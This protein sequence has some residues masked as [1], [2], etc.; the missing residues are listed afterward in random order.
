[1]VAKSKDDQEITVFRGLDGVV[2]AETDISFVDGIQGDLYYK[3]YNIHD[4]ADN[5][6]SY[7]EVVY[8][9]LNGELPTIRQLRDFRRKA[10]SDMRV[11]TQVIKM[12]EIMPPSS[13]PMDV[14]RTAVSA[15]SHFDSDA[16][17]DSPKASRRKGI[18]LIAQIPTLVASLYRIRNNKNIVSPDP[19]MNMAENILY[20]F[21]GSIPEKNH[22]G[23][24]DLLL[25]LHA[26]HGL[27]A[28]TFAARVA[29][30]THADMHAA[31]TSALSTLKGPLHG[32]ANERVMKMLRKINNVNEVEAY[33][34]SMLAQGQRVMGFGHRVYN[35]EDPRA[36]HLRSMSKELCSPDENKKLHRISQKIEDIVMKA[37][38][39]YPN[40]DFYSAT[41]Q[42]A[43]GIPP[44]FYTALFASSRIS[45]W[46]T[47]ILDQYANNRLIRPTSKYIGKYNREFI[48]ISER[49]SQKKDS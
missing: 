45:G 38:G 46:V 2:A 41:V 6:I 26:D 43:I 11:P 4:I 49:T 1:M 40:V 42:H 25:L 15:L 27:N 30:S 29:A 44:E 35:K 8:L 36:R 20:M 24:M 21:H 28:S 18:R 39:I 9:L 14:L 31:V 37:K 32:G 7:V 10:V 48:P 17:D 22:S 13:H 12:M 5:T 23:A 34:N 3:G 19:Q 16:K 47:H 33:I